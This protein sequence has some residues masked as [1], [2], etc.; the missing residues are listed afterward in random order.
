MESKYTHNIIWSDEDQCFVVT[1]SEF[2]NLSA[3]GETIREAVEDAE[4]VLQM[5][6]ESLDRDGIAHPT[7]KVHT[8][9]EEFSGQVRLRVPKSLHKELVTVASAEGVSLNTHMIHLLSKQNTAS[10]INSQVLRKIATISQQQD[11]HFATMH[12]KLENGPSTSAKPRLLSRR[13]ENWSHSEKIY[14]FVR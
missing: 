13:P 2:P 1:F 10:L 8:P 3:F 5:A 7:P 4:L 14:A 9:S 6:L 11:Q 12:R